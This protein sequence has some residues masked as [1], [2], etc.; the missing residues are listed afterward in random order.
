MPQQYVELEERFSSDD[1]HPLAIV[2]TRGEK[3][4]VWQN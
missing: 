2:I 4:F 3:E 1:H